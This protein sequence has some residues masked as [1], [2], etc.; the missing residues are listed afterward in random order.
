M[1]RSSLLH[2]LP[3]T[4]ATALTSIVA[5][6]AWGTFYERA[7]DLLVPLA[8][9][10]VLVSV[11]GVLSRLARLPAVVVVGVQLLG[12]FLAAN[13]VWGSSA[14]PTPIP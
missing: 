6:L 8:G 2:T 7:G 10:I 9:G 13:V 4:A 11:L 1:S 5:F 14:W 3:L 12:I